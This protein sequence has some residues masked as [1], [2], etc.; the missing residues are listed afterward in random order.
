MKTA[1]SIPN[2]VFEAAEKMARRLGLSRSQLYTNAVSEFL[3][4]HFSDDVTEKL[5]QIY[6][7]ESSELDPGTRALQYASIDEGD[8]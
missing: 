4:R 8:W 7:T 6:D 5:N 1:I 2:E 3:R